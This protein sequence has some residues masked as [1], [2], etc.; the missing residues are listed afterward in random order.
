MFVL[1]HIKLLS[2]QQV[3]FCLQLVVLLLQHRLRQLLVVLRLV[4]WL[5]QPLLACVWLAEDF[6]HCWPAKL[7][8]QAAALG[9]PV[10]I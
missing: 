4:L 8:P 9:Q 7:V 5:L 10:L 3:H 1:N 6:P 2:G